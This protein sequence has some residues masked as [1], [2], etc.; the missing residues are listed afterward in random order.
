VGLKSSKLETI[1]LLPL[2]RKNPNPHISL[3]DPLRKFHQASVAMEWLKRCILN[4]FVM[5]LCS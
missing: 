2:V 5:L 1:H 3:F 4:G